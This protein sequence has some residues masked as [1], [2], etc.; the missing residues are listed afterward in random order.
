MSLTAGARIGVYEVI[1]PIGSGGMGDVY[2]ARDTRLHRDVAL[3]ILPEAFASDPDRISRFER[4]AHVLASLNHP[5]IAQIYGFEERRALVME[6][7]DGETLADRLARGPLP[8]DE[9]IVVARQI[10]DALEAA[11]GQGIIHRDLKPANIKVRPDGTVK[12]LDFGLARVAPPPDGRPASHGNSMSPTLT[13]PALMTGVGTL[14]GT[15]VYMAPEQARGR[16]ADAR[17]DIWAFGCVVYEMLAG[18]RAFDGEG[19]TE[20]LASVLMGEPDWKA[21]PPA[22][23]P[24]VDRLIRRCLRKD[25]RQRLHDIA[26]ARIELEEPLPEAAAPAPRPTRPTTAAR[27]L[28]AAPWALA[29]VLLVAAGWQTWRLSR[30]DAAAPTPV[31]FTIAPSGALEFADAGWP[32]ATVSPDGSRVVL[33]YAEGGRPRLYLRRL[34]QLEATPIPGVESGDRPFFSPDGRWLA[35]SDGGTLK[36]I[37]IDGG[38]STVVAEADWGNGAW[39]HDDTIVYTPHYSAGLWRVPSGGG[40]PQELTKPDTSKGELGHWW[41]QF[42]PD[43]RT[44]LFTAFTV[45]AERS[46]I[47]TLSLDTGERRVVLDGGMFGRYAPTG[48][49]LFSRATTVLAVP[50]DAGR[51]QTSGQPTPVLAGVAGAFSNGM[52]HYS[53]A[54]NGTLVHISDAALT[55]PKRLA[56][57]DRKGAAEPLAPTPRRFEAP[58]LSPDGRRIAV[59]VYDQG[60]RDVWVYEIERGTLTRATF[61]PGAQFNPVWSHDSRR[62]F[63]AFEEPVFHIY[64]RDLGTTAAAE[65]LVDGPYDVTPAAVTADGRFLLYGRNTPATRNDIWMLPL[66]GEPRTPRAVVETPYEEQNPAISPDG[67]WIAYESNET[68]RDEI[69]VQRFPAGGDRVQ[70]S[71]DGGRQPA[72]SRDGRELV[73]RQVDTMLA[74]AMTTGPDARVGRPAPLFTRRVELGTGIAADGRFL[75]L[76]R[77]PGAPPAPA[78]VVLNWSEELKRLSPWTR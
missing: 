67:Q 15:A 32:V 71:T 36:K 3:K 70:V 25:P 64:S 18:R 43:G 61:A 42:L 14:L 5:H 13:S 66:T 48:H 63:F 68:G 73:F 6:L 24:G 8:V 58:S 19:V 62:L 51:R 74:A 23:P 1:A 2:R 29:A 49:L 57:V 33:V 50:F 52:S 75:G 55:V 4:E 12:V 34:D 59:A 54:A 46:R 39:G 22:T 27:V 53:L 41:P 69:Y 72:W 30:A 78:H 47:E 28:R 21:L 17:A 65:R 76:Q 44:V 11:H 20:T 9:A 60:D 77:D 38:A 10:A 37:S 31:R 7:V 26:D 45:P 16:A 35:F 40:T 56:W